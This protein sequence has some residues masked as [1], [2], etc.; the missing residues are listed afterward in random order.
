[1]RARSIKPGFFKNEEL[2]AC[3]PWPMLLFCG[4][5]M[6]A[7]RAGR[8]ELRPERIRAELF[9]YQQRPAGARRC[10]QVLDMLKALEASNFIQSYHVN[11]CNY[12][13]ITNF[14]KHQNPHIRELESSIEAPGEHSASILLAGPST[15]LAPLTPDSG[16]RT[17]HSLTPPAPSDDFT[18]MSKE[19]VVE[20][21]VQ[22]PSG[23]WFSEWWKIYWLHKARASAEKA[24]RNHV[25]CWSRFQRVMTA[26]R[27]QTPEMLSR[28]PSKRPY[29]ATW[30]NGE[31][32]DDE[33]FPIPTNGKR[34]YLSANPTPEGKS[35]WD[36]ACPLTPDE[37]A[38]AEQEQTRSR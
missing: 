21:E 12:I 31:R 36:G 19:L 16:L 17:P 32:W 10:P 14:S 2:A 27:E 9:P 6:L 35:I 4:L 15:V 23:T 18:L 11:G 28:E 13:Q 20:P 22:T 24:F 38:A 33:T 34:P 8:L 29:G 26:T 25:H 1:M 30:L 3:G 5:W 37:L 7:D